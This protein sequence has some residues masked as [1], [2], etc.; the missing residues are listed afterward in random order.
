MKKKKGHKKNKKF[1]KN[2]LLAALIF[3]IGAA[4][5]NPSSLFNLSEF[6]SYSPHEILA[7]C[8]AGCGGSPV[9]SPASQ[10]T[11]ENDNEEINEAEDNNDDETSSE[12][13]P[14][15]KKKKKKK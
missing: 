7:G 12:D 14:K 8:G 2:A 3:S 9:V 5:A 10:V 6:N 13:K 1:N 15:K 4:Q 11:N